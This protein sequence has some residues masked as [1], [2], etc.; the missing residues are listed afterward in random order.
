[1]IAA[2]VYG[3]TGTGL[4]LWSIRFLSSRTFFPYHAEASGMTWESVP[5]RL[6]YL[7]LI[8][9]RV[10]GSALL[11]ISVLVVAGAVH[12]YKEDASWLRLAIPAVIIA[13]LGA[14]FLITYGVYRKTGANAPWK[15][16]LAWMIPN[17]IT[18]V[19]SFFS[20][21]N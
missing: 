12:L 4:L 14:L 1:M 21:S 9:M 17:L 6:Q 11:I 10:I 18:A 8:L 13:L 2:L 19:Y 20:N 15:M 7:I 16:A 3:L 5:P